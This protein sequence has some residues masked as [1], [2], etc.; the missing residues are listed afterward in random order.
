M[1]VDDEALDLWYRWQH[2][3]KYKYSEEDWITKEEF[4][5]KTKALMQ[6]NPVPKPDY[7]NILPPVGVEIQKMFDGIV[8]KEE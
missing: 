8:I 2:L 7:S 6:K 5:E 1:P 3:G 4:E